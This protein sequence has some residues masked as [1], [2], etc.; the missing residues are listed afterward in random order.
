MNDLRWL[1]AKRNRS[2]SWWWIIAAAI[3]VLII[4]VI[5]LYFFGSSS[6]TSLSTDRGMTALHHMTKGAVS[7]SFAY[8]QY[9]D[10]EEI[11]YID[12]TTGQQVSSAQVVN[13]EYVPV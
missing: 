6:S 4:I 11:E 1:D 13:G 2:G 9:L 5:V 10:G 12:S 7:S 8:P 3:V